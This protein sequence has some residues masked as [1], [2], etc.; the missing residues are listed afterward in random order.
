MGARR[1][2]QPTELANMEQASENGTEEEPSK[3]EW[4]GEG[5]NE[6]WTEEEREKKR[7]FPSSQC[8]KSSNRKQDP[9]RVWESFPFL[10][11]SADK[12]GIPQFLC[13]RILLLNRDALLV[14]PVSLQVLVKTSLAYIKLQLNRFFRNEFRL[15]PLRGFKVVCC[16]PW[17]RFSSYGGNKSQIRPS[18]CVSQIVLQ[19]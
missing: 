9:K 8:C 14:V 13:E 4:S 16:M 19:K 15:W 5:T 7:S 12:N 11:W 3:E 17:I 6:L 18:H 2:G 10:G 1:T